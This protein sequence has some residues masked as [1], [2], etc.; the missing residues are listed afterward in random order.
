M[1][2][3]PSCLLLSCLALLPT[4]AA[5]AVPNAPL[6][7]AKASFN[8]DSQAVEHITIRGRTSAGQDLFARFSMANAG[9]KHGELDVT[10]RME[11][12]GGTYYGNQKFAQGAYT[13]AGDHLGVRAG[14][15]ALEV[16][17]G[18]LVATFDFGDIKGTVDVT[19]QVAPL[20]VADRR[21]DF[22]VRDVVAPIAR[23]AVHASQAER[24][25]DASCPGFAVHEA[26]N[27]TAHKVYDRAIQVHNMGGATFAVIDYIDLPAERGGR[28][29][30]FVAISQKGRTFV[31]EVVKEN[32]ELDHADAEFDYQVPWQV[33]VLAKRGDGRA[34]VRLT[35]ERQVGKEDDL[36]DLGFI[37][38]KAVGALMHP[39]TYTLKGQAVGEMQLSATDVAQI[40]EPFPLRYK[41]A[42]VR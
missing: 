41:Y 4:L 6:Y 26:S 12:P 19:P 21:G 33:T 5:A 42:Q 18:H 31:G 14:G 20:V 10:F 3:H 16:Q 32:R 29:L 28:T 2:R 36:K 13:V 35:A 38:R 34:A 1:T 17:G 15:N 30:G 11:A 7:W 22:I 24:I 9:F 25:F 40:L 39:V 8:D 23:I 27:A 37:A